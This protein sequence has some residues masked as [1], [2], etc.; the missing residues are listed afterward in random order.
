M[1]ALRVKRSGT[2]TLSSLTL[3][4]PLACIPMNR[5]LPQSGRISNWPLGTVKKVCFGGPFSCI[6]MPPPM[7]WVEIGMPE[8]NGQTPLAI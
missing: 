8:A 7:K 4:E 5:S 3:F 6:T 2:N 1:L